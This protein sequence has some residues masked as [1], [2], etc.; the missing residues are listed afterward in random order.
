MRHVRLYSLTKFGDDPHGFGKK[1]TGVFLPQNAFERSVV[2][3]D[4]DGPIRHRAQQ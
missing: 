2:D 4:M 1:V 3:W